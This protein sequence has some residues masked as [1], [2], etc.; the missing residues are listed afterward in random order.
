[1][2]VLCAWC[3][4]E[5]KPALLGEREPFDDPKET[6]GICGE[7]AHRLMAELGPTS[8]AGV[9][10]LVV[11]QPRE[12]SVFEYL[13]EALGGVRGVQVMLD[14]RAGRNGGVWPAERERRSERRVDPWGEPTLGYTM[15]RLAPG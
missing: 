3:Q 14:R 2:K 15:I 4:R 1:M 13:L 12:T 5:G 6:H 10:V 7:H 11:V 9:E 8:L